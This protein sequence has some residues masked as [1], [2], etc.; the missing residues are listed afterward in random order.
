MQVSN[1]Y[2]DSIAP[3]SSTVIAGIAA[4]N[5]AYLSNVTLTCRFIILPSIFKADQGIRPAPLSR[6]VFSSI[7][8]S[9]LIGSANART[10]G[11]Q[12]VQNL[13]SR[14]GVLG[15]RDESLVSQF[16]QFPESL[17]DRNV[18]S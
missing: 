3:R 14:G 4:S 18:R 5:N 12:A 6:R 2:P 11:L 15:V 16:L 10:G 17:L 13:L 8:E 1:R 9:W 7:C